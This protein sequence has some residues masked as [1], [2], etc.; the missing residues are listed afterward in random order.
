MSLE[1]QARGHGWGGAKAHVWG[2]GLNSEVQCIMGNGHMGT[3]P[4][5]TDMIENITFP[6]LRW[7]AVKPFLFLDSPEKYFIMD[8]RDK[9]GD[10]PVV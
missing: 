2:G 4:R 1:G 7:R 10:V 8:G 3:H 9:S 5:K 6:R